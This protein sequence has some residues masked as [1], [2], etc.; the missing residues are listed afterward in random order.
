MREEFGRSEEGGCE[1]IDNKLKT[2]PAPAASN[3]S[4]A[5]HSQEIPTMTPNGNAP[6]AHP[7]G[8]SGKGDK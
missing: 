7:V 1:L 4:P 6:A 5:N 3:M 2:E 8:L